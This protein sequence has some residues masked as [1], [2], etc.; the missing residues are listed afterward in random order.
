[1][2]Q[3]VQKL[4]YA[5]GC[6]FELARGVIIFAVVLAL[7]TVFIA[8]INVVNGASMEPNFHDR[9]YVIVDKLSYYFRNPYRGEAVII[10][11]PGDPDKVK[12]IKRIVGM[13][14]ETIKIE[15]NIVYINNKPLREA[16][17]PSDYLTEPNNEWKLGKN[18]YFLMGDNR[19]NSNDSRV[20]GAVE[21]RFLIGLAYMVIWPPK[22]TK[23]VPPEY[24]NVPR[25]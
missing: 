18:E 17:I 7:I 25:Q 2:N 1:M 10:K 20:F 22:D 11:F 21:K 14:G 6:A 12:Y 23:L 15:D 9:Q 8:T 4:L 24:Y 3:W 16:Y 5:T 19:Q 13:P